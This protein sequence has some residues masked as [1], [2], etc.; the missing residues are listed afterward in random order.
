MKGFLLG[1]Q[2]LRIYWR[3]NLTKEFQ[4]KV[5]KELEDSGFLVIPNKSSLPDLVAVRKSTGKKIGV[6]CISD[7]NYTIDLELKL[8]HIWTLYDVHPFIARAEG[9]EIVFFDL[10]YT[11]DVN[12]I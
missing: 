5:V 2:E 8:S 7:G 4:D 6:Q 9:K 3:V 1:I 12:A 10:I 11:E